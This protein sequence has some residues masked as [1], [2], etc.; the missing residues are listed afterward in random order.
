MKAEIVIFVSE[1][2]RRYLDAA[3]VAEVSGVPGVKLD[4]KYR[5]GA[6]A[7]PRDFLWDGRRMWYAEQSLPQLA[8]ALF[9]VGE[10]DAAIRLRSWLAVHLPKVF[11]AGTA[12]THSPAAPGAPAGEPAAASTPPGRAARVD[13]SWM[14][15]WEAGQS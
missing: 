5:P 9:A 2:G 3:D 13:Q 14:N 10:T 12:A 7:M 15:R 8:D 4:V 6:W 11:D 1:A